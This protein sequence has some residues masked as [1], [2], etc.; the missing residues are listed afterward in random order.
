V[1]RYLNLAERATGRVHAVT[2]D[3]PTPILVWP[4]ESLESEAK[5][6]APYARLFP[7]IGRKVR[8]P[9][10]AG[11]LL[12]VFR[13]RCAVALD[14]EAQKYLH[15]FPPG[16]IEPVSWLVGDQ[17]LSPKPSRT[18]LEGIHG[19]KPEAD[20]PSPQPPA[21]CERC[22]SKP[23]THTRK[24]KVV[25]YG[26]V[27]FPDRWFCDECAPRFDV[28]APARLMYR[29]PTPGSGLPCQCGALIADD[30]ERSAHTGVGGCPLRRPK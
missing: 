17:D 16:E 1:G 25:F 10:G 11:V 5:F 4:P 2:C 23:S 22:H 8:T 12:Q 27:T 6:G 29:P 3:E 18:V 15:F 24:L 20:K 7:F 26:K 30:I 13:E 21:V 28:D 9:D 14:V 19:R